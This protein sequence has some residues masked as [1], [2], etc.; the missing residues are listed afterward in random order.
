MFILTKFPLPPSSN[1]LYASVRGRLVKSQEGR[2]Y[3]NLIQLYKLKK[4][5]DLER[6]THAFTDADVLNIETIF[7]FAR[8][9]IVGQ[10]GQ[11][12]KLDASNRI[13]QLHDGL[14]KLI[15]IDDCRFVSGTFSKATCEK[16][17]DEQVIIKIT[18]SQL[19]SLDQLM[20]G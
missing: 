13:K 12:K 19:F 2:K 10:K 1:Q 5:R 7:V 17:C 9:R 11:I 4:F 6:I 8:K 3:D 15:G 20:I 14:S 16:E 18:K